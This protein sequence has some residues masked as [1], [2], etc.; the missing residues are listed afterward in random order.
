MN[1]G[2]LISAFITPILRSKRYL[3]DK[4]KISS[5]NYFIGDVQCFG[6]DCY[7]LAFGVPALLMLISISNNSKSS[8]IIYFEISFVVIFIMGTPIYIRV[9]PKENIITKF[10]AI[11]WVK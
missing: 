7:P 11:I 1:I 6:Y 8:L 10:L 4:K 3:L 9:A 2:S 5:C